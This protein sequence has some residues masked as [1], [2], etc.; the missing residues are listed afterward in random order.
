VF[1][2]YN[3]ILCCVEIG[4]VKETEIHKK[5][6]KKKKERKKERKKEKNTLAIN[7]I[8]DEFFFP[9]FQEYPNF[10]ENVL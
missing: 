3:I 5:K 6:R 8:Q 4:N 2:T 1:Y 9:V 10:Y 7:K